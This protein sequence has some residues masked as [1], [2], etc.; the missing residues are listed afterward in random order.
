MSNDRKFGIIVA[1]VIFLILAGV[2]GLVAWAVHDD[3]KQAARNRACTGMIEKKYTGY[4]PGVNVNVGGYKGNGGVGIP[5]GNGTIY[6]FALRSETGVCE[7]H[8][9]KKA[10]LNNDEGGYYGG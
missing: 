1:L 6:Y 2:I 9:S 5:V 4:D 3:A 7:R 10:W 8:V